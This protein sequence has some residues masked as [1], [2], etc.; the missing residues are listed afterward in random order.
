MWADLE[1]ML[2]DLFSTFSDPRGGD[3]R[4]TGGS[5]LLN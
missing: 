1:A 3:F 5:G 2:S 4:K